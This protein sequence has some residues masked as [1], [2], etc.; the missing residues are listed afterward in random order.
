MTDQNRLIAA[1]AAAARQSYSPYSRYRVGAVVV[2]SNGAEYTGCNVENAAYGAS[3]CAEANAI[4]NAVADGVREI[5]TV[6]V[7]CLDGDGCSPCGNCRQI[8]REFGVR[9]VILTDQAGDPLEYTLDDLL[10]RSFGP[11]DLYGDR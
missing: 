1:A 2:A 3:I 7:M 4:T 5:D 9:R 6:A 8:M 11:E 10:P